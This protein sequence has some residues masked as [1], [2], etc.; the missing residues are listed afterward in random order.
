MC[1]GM[2]R[3][4]R[5]DR[6]A[7]NPRGLRTAHSTPRAEPLY[8]IRTSRPTSTR[9]I[10]TAWAALTLRISRSASPLGTRGRVGG[11]PRERRRARLPPDAQRRAHELRRPREIAEHLEEDER[12]RIGAL[13]ERLPEGTPE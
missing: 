4:K 9:R 1:R 8:R 13:D 10:S 5:R 6:I 2:K 11:G 3:V 12:R 7:T